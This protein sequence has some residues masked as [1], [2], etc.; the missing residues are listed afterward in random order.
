MTQTADASPPDLQFRDAW[1]AFIRSLRTLVNGSIADQPRYLDQWLQWSEATL[2]AAEAPDIAEALQGAYGETQTRG[3]R[4][5]ADLLLMELLAYTQAVNV[6]LQTEE[7]GSPRFSA[8][9]A[10]FSIGKT[11]I[12][13]TKDVFGHF[14]SNRPEVQSIMTVLGEVPD[15]MGA[16]RKEK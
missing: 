14:L 3:T 5:A 6:A 2:T 9:Q 13:S 8:R 7:P 12:G 11:V 16:F 10:L 15:V 4:K 1:I